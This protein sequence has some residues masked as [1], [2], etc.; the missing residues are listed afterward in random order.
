M[1]SFLKAQ[2]SRQR[3]HRERVNVLDKG[4]LERKKDYQTR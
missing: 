4:F 1:R 2:K 3:L